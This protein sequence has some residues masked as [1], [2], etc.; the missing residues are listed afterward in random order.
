MEWALDSL[1]PYV[2]PGTVHPAE[3]TLS[4]VVPMEIKKP[5]AE[6][7][8]AARG[9]DTSEHRRSILVGTEGILVIRISASLLY[10]DKKFFFQRLQISRHRSAD[11][12]ANSADACRGKGKDAGRFQ[13]RGAGTKSVLLGGVASRFPKPTLK[14]IVA[15]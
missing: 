9:D 5:P 1:N 7:S 3:K 10:P 15:V 2:F 14:W 13:L 8:R 12:T 6:I 11:H 4:D